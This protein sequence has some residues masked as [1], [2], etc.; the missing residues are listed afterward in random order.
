MIEIRDVRLSDGSRGNIAI[1]GK[2]IVSAHALTQKR[3]LINGKGYLALPGL[4]D[5]HVHFRVPGGE[6]KETWETGCLS[7]KLGGVT[8]VFDMPNTNPALTTVEGIEKKA[9]CIGNPD[10]NYRFWFGATPKNIAE[11]I[12]A[13]KDPRIIGV[14]V[15]MGSSTGDLLVCDD[16]DIRKIFLA[17]AEFGITVAVHAEDEALMRKNIASLGRPARVSDHCV[18]REPEVEIS[19]VRRALK[20]QKETQCRLYFCHLSTP[21]SLELV[22]DAK[23][24]GAEIF[25]EVCP[26]YILLSSEK[27]QGDRG[28]YFKMNPPLRSAHDIATMQDYVCREGF[29]DTIGSDH[30]P[31]TREEKDSKEYEK[32]PSGVPG[33]QTILPILLTFFLERS[34]PID[35]FVD[36][37]SR[38]A[39]K[40]FKLTA[41]GDIAP[42]YDADIVLADTDH[43]KIIRNS[44]MATRCGWT[45]FDGYEVCV[46]PKIV[47][48]QGVVSVL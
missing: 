4:I 3:K 22:R 25:A 41:N 16:G 38:N 32:V 9:K 8:T 36:L 43:E 21:K 2:R 26:H 17:C 20:L 34:V 27:I 46:Q 5:T 40:I 23:D 31:H 15:Y 18:I 6:H 29:V 42:G 1:L 30:A 47:V 19:A 10:I 14:K 7:A 48:C 11:I 24:S 39:A 37:T 13:R 12:E 35:N 33:A 28:A 44:Q 45:P